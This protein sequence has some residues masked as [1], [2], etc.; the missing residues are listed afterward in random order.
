M[1][2]ERSVL[3]LS[4]AGAFLS[5][6]LIA[7]PARAQA[8]KWPVTYR[9]YVTTEVKSQ[10]QSVQPVAARIIGATSSERDSRLQLPAGGQMYMYGMAT[11][12]AWPGAFAGGQVVSV[13]NASGIKSAEVSVTTKPSITFSTSAAYYAG[14]GIGVSGF[15][16]VRGYYASNEGPAASSVRIQID[17]SAPALVT[18]IGT[19]SSQQDVKFAGLPGMTVDV[20]STRSEA[21]S[22][23]HTYLGPGTY[24]ISEDSFTLS[25]GQ[26]ASY[27]ADLMA[28]FIFSDQPADVSSPSQ[29]IFLPTFNGHERMNRTFLAQ[30]T[31]NVSSVG[32]HG[33][34]SRRGLS[35]SPPVTRQQSPRKQTVWPPKNPVTCFAL[36]GSVVYAGTGGDGVLRTKNSGL[37]WTSVNSGLTSK[38]VNA[39][40]VDGTQLFA[41]TSTGVFVS[42]SGSGEWKAAGLSG[43]DVTSLVT[44]HGDLFATT[45]TEGDI[46]ISHDNGQTWTQVNYATA[47]VPRA[48]VLAVDNDELFAGTMF[49]VLRSTRSLPGSASGAAGLPAPITTVNGRS[50]W[51]MV[52][53][54]IWNKFISY[55][56]VANTNLYAGTNG[57][58]YRSSDLGASWVPVDNGLTNRFVTPLFRRLEAFERSGSGTDLTT[59]DVN[60]LAFSSNA[61]SES[62]IFAGTDGGIFLSTD[63]GASWTFAGLPGVYITSVAISGKVVFAGAYGG[64][65]YVSTTGG[66][67]WVRTH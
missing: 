64:V 55:L 29:V 18:V 9:A 20:P 30:R 54:D 48:S 23:A 16:Y 28:V 35:S 13:N 66:K 38:V 6:V 17:L 1:N 42:E 60:A 19:A 40:V 62:K 52:K 49:G 32:T 39:L 56:G 65:I 4:M 14:A 46:L 37:T 58:L 36:R 34:T 8:N 12:G 57:Y 51:T 26:T 61:A 5:L 59:P 44:I 2:K 31:S 47:L 10:G 22:I 41:G 11:G 50:P 45:F 43:E 67:R 27:Q 21:V 25:A 53:S 33:T 3:R 63:D 7:V 15:R 24:N